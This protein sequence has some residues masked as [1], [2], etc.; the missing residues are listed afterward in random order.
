MAPVHKYESST[1]SDFDTEAEEEEMEDSLVIQ[2]I[3]GERDPDETTEHTEEEAGDESKQ[4]YVK[5]VD[6]AHIHNRWLKEWEII[7]FD[8]GENALRRYQIKLDRNGLSQSLSIPSL[9]TVD[10]AQVN[11]FWFEADRI[12]D[13]RATVR[14]ADTSSSGS[15]LATT[16]RRG[17]RR[18][19]S[20][21]R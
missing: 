20:R 14:I 16:K 18:R 17:K 3:L 12:I 11:S 4:Y 1:E 10:D 21:K 6:K 19:T 7:E 13:Q 2:N 15:F 8:G 5:F 9:L